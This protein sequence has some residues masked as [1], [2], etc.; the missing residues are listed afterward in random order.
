MTQDRVESFQRLRIKPLFQA[1]HLALHVK[2]LAVSRAYYERLG[3]RVVSKPSP[4][5][6]EIMLGNQ[7]LH[8]LPAARSAYEA[9]RSGVNHFCLSVASLAD[10]QRVA[11]LVGAEIEESEMLG[12]GLA[13][14]CEERPPLRTAYFADPDGI[15]IELRCYTGDS[16]LTGS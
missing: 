7:R 6:L 3:G 8:I 14:H 2:D 11:A 10:L 4:H 9:E 16:R 1:D 12:E 15:G 5:F 13:E